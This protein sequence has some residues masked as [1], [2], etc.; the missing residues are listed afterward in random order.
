MRQ[1]LLSFVKL[2]WF[3]LAILALATIFVVNVV[4][5]AQ[6]FIEPKD[7]RISTLKLIKPKIMKP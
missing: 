6:Q 5:L 4:V 2:N 3:K 1:Q 7:D